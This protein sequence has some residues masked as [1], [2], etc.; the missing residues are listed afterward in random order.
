V[1]YGGGEIGAWTFKNSDYIILL[2]LLLEDMNDFVVSLKVR[3][4]QAPVE[5]LVLFKIKYKF[6]TT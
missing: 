1:K 3:I 5:D 6:E 4:V 2:P